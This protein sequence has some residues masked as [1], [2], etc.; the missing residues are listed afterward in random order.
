MTVDELIEDMK[1]KHGGKWTGNLLD[2]F[3][4]LGYTSGPY[5]SLS[6]SEEDAY[7]LYRDLFNWIEKA[8]KE[9]KHE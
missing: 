9:P 5:R 8:I 7:S 3:L 4:N 6:L 2:M 1:S